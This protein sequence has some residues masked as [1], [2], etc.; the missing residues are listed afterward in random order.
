MNVF[1]RYRS[2]L[3]ST[4]YRM[5]PLR[6]TM[7]HC[8]DID[9]LFDLISGGNFIYEKEPEYPDINMSFSLGLKEEIKQVR[10]DSNR[11]RISCC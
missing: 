2:K 11:R 3:T 7:T 6:K 4:L 8:C 9:D 10:Y 1:D 5:L